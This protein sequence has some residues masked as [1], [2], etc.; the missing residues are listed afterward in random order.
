LKDRNISIYFVPAFVL[1]VSW[2]GVLL[3]RQFSL[4]TFESI[5]FSTSVYLFFFFLCFLAGTLIG[6]LFLAKVAYTGRPVFSEKQVEA[7]ANWLI[8]LS[9]ISV[10]LLTFKFFTLLG[11][12]SF[13]LADIT[14]LRLSRGRDAGEAKGTMI[15]GILGMAMSGFPVVAY[16]F[17]EYFSRELSPRKNKQ[18]YVVFLLGIFVSFLSGGRFAAAIALLIVFIVFLLKK[19][20]V[21]YDAER[22]ISK[23]KKTSIKKKKKGGFFS[24]LL[25]FSLYAI[26]LYIFSIIFINRAIG[27]DE[28]FK[29]LLNVL[30]HNFDGISVPWGHKAF[31]Q[32]Y[33]ILIPLYFVIS[34]FQYYIGHAIYQ[35]D[36]LLSAP[37][38]SNAPYWLQ[39]QFYLYT[40]LFN[41]V[42]F[43]FMT[44]QEI[45]SEIENPGVY[46]TLPGAFFLD[47]GYWGSCVTIFLVSLLG[48]FYWVRFVKQK[49]FFDFYISILF[50]VL[51]LFSP[52]VAITGTGVYPSLLSIVFVIKIF[53]PPGTKTTRVI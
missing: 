48:S 52:I 18:L 2:A 14:D 13:S 38:P 37:Y 50:L 6:P 39:Y 15:S 24:K 19:N 29:I 40:S 35:F 51:I 26:I 32:E 7:K 10:M 25:K 36:V 9:L 30:S 31:L 11:D 8:F 20:V 4:I 42:G 22:S 43:G 41:K 5:S 33:P 49:K 46:L 16:I 1:I 3:I 27:D 47:F 45:L 44:I 28:N 53:L 23:T 34:L 17:R 12:M 21:S